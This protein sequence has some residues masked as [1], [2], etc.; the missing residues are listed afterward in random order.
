MSDLEIELGLELEK[1]HSRIWALEAAL[2]EIAKGLPESGSILEVVVI[3]RAALAGSQ[4][5]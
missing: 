5:K 4:D 3:A 1:A 2:R